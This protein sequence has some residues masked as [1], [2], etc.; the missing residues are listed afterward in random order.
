LKRH[1]GGEVEFVLVPH[2]GKEIRPN[3]TVKHRAIEWGGRLYLSAMDRHGLREF[4]RAALTPKP[5]SNSEY[6]IYLRESDRD[7]PATGLPRLSLEM[8]ARFLIDEMSLDNE[9]GSLRLALDSIIPPILR[10]ERQPE[11]FTA[12]PSLDEQLGSL[13][14]ATPTGTTDRS[15]R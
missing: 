11:R 15:I 13:A 3:M 8:W 2:P 7:K 12:S 9:E 10:K 4:C 5:W 6:G 14:D 1:E